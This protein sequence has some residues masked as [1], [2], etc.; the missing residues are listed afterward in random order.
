MPDTTR[1]SARAP[2]GRRVVLAPIALSVVL[3]SIAAG[4]SG[5]QSSAS[6]ANPS[7]SVPF[8]SFAPAPPATTAPSYIVDA[9]GNVISGSVPDATPTTLGE[10]VLPGATRPAAAKKTTTRR[11]P[12]TTKR[13]TTVAPAT[14]DSEKTGGASPQSTVAASSAKSGVAVGKPTS[15]VASGPGVDPTI[16]TLL[17]PSE[18]PDTVPAEVWAALRK[19]ESGNRYD[20]NTGNGYYGAYQFAAA[21]WRRLGYKGLPHQAAPAVQDEAAKRLQA[22]AGW[23]QWPA[24]SR[25]LG[26]R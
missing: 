12:S 4:R 14:V 18:V 19:C 6:Q 13:P 3:A 22:K 2:R 7:S 23:G 10:I 9:N 11:K 16:T 26:L 8:G 20:I 1:G 5:A 15:T 21:T 24:C 17:A 25:K